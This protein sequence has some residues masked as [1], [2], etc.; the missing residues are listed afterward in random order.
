MGVGNGGGGGGGSGRGGRGVGIG[1]RGG[2]DG[3]GR[4]LAALR[5]APSMRRPRGDRSRS[6]PEAVVVVVNG[7]DNSNGGGGGAGGAGGADFSAGGA[8]LSGRGGLSCT[9]PRKRPLS[10]ELKF[11]KPPD[12]AGR[13]GVQSMGRNSRSMEPSEDRRALALGLAGGGGGGGGDVPMR[14]AMY[15]E[16]FR[17]RPAIFSRQRSL[18][19]RY[20]VGGVSSLHRPVCVCALCFSESI[21]CSFWRLY[22]TRHRLHRLYPEI[23]LR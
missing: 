10:W 22:S 15:G 13:G 8:D 6:P 14:P 18:S 11:A 1:G 7:R 4:G 3:G 2:G 19:H 23:P 16:D 5:T 21:V 20:V 9:P 17:E 12:G